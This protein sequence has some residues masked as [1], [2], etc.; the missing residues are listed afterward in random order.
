MKRVT[1]TS[2]RV[3]HIDENMLLPGESAEIED[4]RAES[5]AVKR[6]VKDKYVSLG[7][8]ESEPEPAPKPRA[9]AHPQAQPQAR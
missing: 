8:A 9:P 3:I 7:A 2:L 4:E 6:L 5:E 1:N